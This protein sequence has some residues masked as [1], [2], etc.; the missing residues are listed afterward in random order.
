MVSLI[1]PYIYIYRY[2]LNFT[3]LY[4]QRVAP[5]QGLSDPDEEGGENLKMTE[6]ERSEKPNPLITLNY[7]NPK[8]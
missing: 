7:D 3:S 5:T 6:E 8:L 2:A 1:S 4:M